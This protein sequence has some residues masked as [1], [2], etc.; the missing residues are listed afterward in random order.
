M[1]ESERRKA[2]GNLWTREEIDEISAEV[3]WDVWTMRGG[4]YR[5]KGTEINIPHCRHTWKQHIIISKA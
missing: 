1:K 4:W 3:G 5:V 2:E